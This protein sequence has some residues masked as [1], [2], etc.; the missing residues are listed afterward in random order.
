VKSAA[1]LLVALAACGTRTVEKQ[2]AWPAGTVL[3]LD[4]RAIGAPEVDEAAGIIA[5]LQPRDSVD[6]LRRLALTNIVLPRCAAQAIDPEARLQAQQRAAA[7]QRALVAGTPLA[8]PRPSERKGAMLQLGLELWNAL[9]PLAPGEWTPV[10]ETPGCFQVARLKE[11]GTA[12]LPGQVEL[13]AE[14]YDFP[15]LPAEDTHE[16]IQA[17][18]DRS[19]LVYVDESWRALVPIAW[20]HKLRGESQ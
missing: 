7:A 2:P 11:K 19:R 16:R 20:Q 15:Y 8:D 18:L 17:Q 13:T 6:Q 3:A 4:Q 12:P 10:V 1:L 5:Q 14:V 9:M